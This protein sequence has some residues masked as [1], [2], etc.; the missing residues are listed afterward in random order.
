MSS[1][2]RLLQLTLTISVEVEGVDD[3][4]SRDLVVEARSDAKVC[5]LVE[6]IATEVGL[7]MH[8]SLGLW[9]SFRGLQYKPEDGHVVAC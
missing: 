4:E 6:V 9:R 7:T 5:D 1:T 2:A 8:P 3:K